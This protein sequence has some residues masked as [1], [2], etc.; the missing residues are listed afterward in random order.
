KR[1]IRVLRPV[2]VTDGEGDQRRAM[3]IDPAP[4]SALRVRTDLR[5]FGNMHW[6][7]ALTPAAFATEIAPS[8]SYGRVKWAVPAI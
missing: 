2:V 3:R 4:R 1:F 8:R 6:D 5:G 7:G